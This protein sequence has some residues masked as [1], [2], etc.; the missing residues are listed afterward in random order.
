MTRIYL[1]FV[2]E[3]NEEAIKLA[4]H[5][6][7]NYPQAFVDGSEPGIEWNHLVERIQRCDIFMYLVSPAALNNE[8][9][10]NQLDVARHQKK[11]AVAL[12]MT[13]SSGLFP[14]LGE[15]AP[16][17][18]SDGITKSNLFAVDRSLALLK[19]STVRSRLRL[20]L[21]ILIL[22]IAAVLIGVFAVMNMGDDDK[23]S[24]DSAQTTS[25]STQTFL[26]SP[27][28]TGNVRVIIQ[29]ARVDVRQQN[30]EWQALAES[31]VV[32]QGY[33]VRTSRSGQA[34]LTFF[35]SDRI[36]LLPNTELDLLQLTGDAT[37]DSQ[38][39]A[40][41][42]RG[43]ALFEISRAITE[44]SFHQIT[45]PVAQALAQRGRYE[46]IVGENGQ[47]TFR[48]QEGQLDVTTQDE[49]TSRVDAGFELT[50]TEAGEM[51]EIAQ[52]STSVPTL[53]PTLNVT[54]ILEPSP[55]PTTLP[56]TKISTDLPEASATATATSTTSET[57]G[58]STAANVLET[59][60]VPATATDEPEVTASPSA[61][62]TLRSTNTA[63]S[64]PTDT[65]TATRANT[66]T[67][68][69]TLTPSATNTAAFTAFPTSTPRPANTL[70]PSNTPLPTNTALPSPTSTPRPTITPTI[71]ATINPNIECPGAPVSRLNVEDTALVINPIGL[72]VR[73]EPGLSGVI[74]E[75]VAEGAEVVIVNGPECANGY[76]WWFV[77]VDNNSEGWVAEGGSD[78]YYLE[79][80]QP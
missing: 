58:V 32:T 13:E 14:V 33:T 6:E 73:E 76:R 62:S 78:S 37:G 79:P 70:P 46:V 4:E 45:S 20:P 8:E 64:I 48:V 63:T 52:A 2:P 80:V 47:T 57:E 65:R 59:D 22:L 31:G 12:N 35:N 50:V 74:R 11:P 7:A 40:S 15:I 67:A 53:E 38:A 42:L 26:P 23:D 72:S 17:E 49:Q 43:T 1:C 56:A 60:S 28:P 24:D 16:I 54:A 39:E 10:Y 30:G 77:R 69:A 44:T 5:L 27:N 66:A 55:A 36:Q 75:Y 18:M 61:T 41:L 19:R 9:W 71:G 34:E 3:N 25:E 21:T 51:L 68:T 29:A